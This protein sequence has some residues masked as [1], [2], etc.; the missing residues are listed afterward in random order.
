MKNKYLEVPKHTFLEGK[1]Y[2]NKE[3]IQYV[4]MNDPIKTGSKYKLRI[5]TAKGEAGFTATWE[6]ETEEE[7]EK[8]F[9]KELA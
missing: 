8:F 9:K 5:H 7:R 2:I 4:Y 3:H 1:G 6:F